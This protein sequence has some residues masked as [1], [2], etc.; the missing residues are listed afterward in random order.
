MERRAPVVVLVDDSPSYAVLVGVLLDGAISGGVEVRRHGTLADA[1]ADLRERDADCVLLDL[2]LPDA[3]GLEALATLRSAGIDLPVVALAA[4]DDPELAVAAIAAGAQDVLVKGQERPP[5]AF[6][7]A[8]RFAVARRRAQERSEDLLRAKEDRWRTLTQLAPV[9]I[10]EV[11]AD[12]RCVFA[13]DWTAELC[14]RPH[15]QLLGHGWREA[16]HPDDAERF[17]T[18]WRAAAEGGGVLADEVR[19]VRPDGDVMWAQLTAVLLR[20]PWGGPA[21]WLGTLVDVTPARRAREELHEAEQELRRQ[22]ADVLAISALARDASVLED[23]EAP[24]C[25]GAREVLGAD[26]VV[27][28][29][30][31]DDACLRVAASDGTALPERAEV[32]LDDPRSAAARCFHDGAR[33]E[34]ADVH[35]HP[36][37]APRFAEATRA[38]TVVFEPLLRGPDVLGVVAVG[39]REPCAPLGP[40]TST[41]VGLLAA[42]LAAALERHRLLE[43]LR[44]L[45]R[46]DPLTG[47]PNRRLW[48]ER[49]AVELARAERYAQPLCVAAIDLDRFKPYND[50]HGHQAGDRLLQRLS[51]AWGEAL[52]SSDLLARLGGD[53]FGLLLPDC[54]IGC[55][56]R[57]VARLQGLTP[58]GADEVGCSAGVVCWAPGESAPALLARADAALYATKTS[59]RG[60][61]TVA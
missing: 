17:G 52:R 5:A 4:Q 35:G 24:L 46:T 57:I 36:G 26:F 32:D 8:I 19:F 54:D 25:R 38:R 53:E 6:V 41:L 34:I 18:A 23:A 28:L 7:R 49:L 10:V 58:T 44:N 29:V 20:D 45:A 21:G 37:V 3:K 16:L 12:G 56:R 13:N 39:W 40:R 50:R 47:L 48:D 60:G 15:D 11:D 2:D 30:A 43:Q 31:R 51:V 9:G 59:G 61:I 1:V 22:Q 14:A 33:V 42:E 27:L 55:A